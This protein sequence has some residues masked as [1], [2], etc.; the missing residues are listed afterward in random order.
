[1]KSQLDTFKP[2]DS[3][4][5]NNNNE[6]T[7]DNIQF[8]TNLGAHLA[9]RLTEQFEK[10][11]VYQKMYSSILLERSSHRPQPQVEEYQDKDPDKCSPDSPFMLV[12]DESQELMLAQRSKEIEVV[13]TDVNHVH[14]ILSQIQVMA[15]QQGSLFDR[16]DVNLDHTRHNLTKAIGKLEQTAA[17]FSL[18]QK[19]LILLFIT[20]LIFLVSLGIFFK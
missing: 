10:F 5:N 14:D 13:L 15:V 20:F 19:R 18:H 7:N 2:D 6:Y 1:M 16:I 9:Y 3:N 4:N 11:Q 8:K 12:L 17:S